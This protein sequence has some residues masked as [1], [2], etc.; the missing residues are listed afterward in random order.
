MNAAEH[1]S[2]TQGTKQQRECDFRAKSQPRCGSV[3]PK[4]AVLG[5]QRIRDINRIEIASSK[6]SSPSE[7]V[8]VEEKLQRGLEFHK[9]P[10]GNEAKWSSPMLKRYVYSGISASEAGNQEHRV[11]G[12]DA[13]TLH[14]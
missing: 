13:Q 5:W 14:L 7:G 2:D 6:R 3:M 1:G 4:C 10:L 9:N 11:S 12:L 8:I